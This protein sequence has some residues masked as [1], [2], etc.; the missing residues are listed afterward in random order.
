MARDRVP[1]TFYAQA[2]L[3][4]R[5][6]FDILVRAFARRFRGDTSVQLVIGGAGESRH[7]L[8][9][10]VEVTG[11]HR[12]VTFLGG[13]PSDAVREAMWKAN[14]FVLPSRAENFGVVLIEA[15]ATG[16][17]V[18]FTRCRWSGGRRDGP[19]RNVASARR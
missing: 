6:G 3:T 7:D 4:P 17:P 1:F 8:E 10:L 15:L 9:G 19:C 5:K 13:I 16:L 2:H 12:Q 18:I 14:C 11:V